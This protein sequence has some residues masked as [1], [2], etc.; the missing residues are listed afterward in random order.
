MASFVPNTRHDATLTS[1]RGVNGVDGTLA[2]ALGQ[3]A[4]WTDGP[5]AVLLGDVA[6]LHDLGSLASVADDKCFVVVVVDNEGGG[7]FDHLPISEAG[8]AFERHF[9]TAPPVSPAQLAQGFP[10][11]CR[12][13]ETTTALRSALKEAFCSAGAGIVIAKVDRG[14]D[15]ER[16]HATWAL[17]ASLING[18][19][20]QEGSPEVSP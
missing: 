14:L 3:G 11:P 15:L 2:T 19:L 9:I 16:H 7:I 20:P 12:E 18:S 13:V 4:V 5:S 10:V 8:Q 6:F 17:A 1:N